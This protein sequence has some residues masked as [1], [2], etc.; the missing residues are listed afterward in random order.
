M[1]KHTPKDKLPEKVKHAAFLDELQ[2]IAVSR[3]AVELMKGTLSPQASARLRG[4]LRPPEVMAGGLARGSENLAK[5]L[6]VRVYDPTLTSSLKKV[7]GVIG[8]LRRGETVPAETWR[9]VAAPLA[10]AQ[11]GG[12]LTVGKELGEEVAGI[13]LDPSQTIMRVLGTKAGK[14]G[15]AAL[16][17]LLGR[18]MSAPERKHLAEIIKR[19][20]VDEARAAARTS[21]FMNVKE[22][23][24]TP[25][26]RSVPFTKGHVQIGGG[27]HADPRVLM[28]E[29]RNLTFAPEN[30][31]STMREIRKLTK[32]QPGM[33]ERAGV[34]MGLKTPPAGS[35]AARQ[36]EKALFNVPTPTFVTP[37]GPVHYS[38]E[39]EQRLRG[40]GESLGSR[41]QQV[42]GLARKLKSRFSPASS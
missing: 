2:K 26:W 24:W 14:G 15:I 31:R 38:P 34:D 20:E 35:R 7:P 27:M 23:P 33:L 39:F 37:Q 25:G 30:V 9:Q 4:V 6:G 3:G 40:F 32:E 8:A 18:G 13:Y 36:A 29:S 22:G 10:A 16:K 11:G 21:S 19:H 1:A 28:E 5:Q 17:E 42:R 12:G 41:V